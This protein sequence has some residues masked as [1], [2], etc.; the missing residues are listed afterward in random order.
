MKKNKLR[1]YWEFFKFP[2][3]CIGVSVSLL[4]FTIFA[5]EVLGI[6]PTDSFLTPKYNQSNLRIS[7][8]D[9]ADLDCDD[10]ITISFDDGTRAYGGWKV[11]EHSEDC[12]YTKEG[13]KRV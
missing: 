6:N 12:I 4:A 8:N 11:G 7:I 3:V 10:V 2:F 5:I 13:W 1:E 9:M